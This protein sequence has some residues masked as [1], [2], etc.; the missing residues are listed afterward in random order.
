MCGIA[1]ILGNENQKQTMNLMI[2][3]MAHRG[4]DGKGIYINEGIALGHTRL[5]ILDLSDNGSQPMFSD[6]GDLVMVFNGEVF[7]YKELAIEH[8]SMNSLKSTSDSEV[9]L[10]LYE[11]YGPDTLKLF[12]GM[13]AIL[14]WNK[15]TKELFGARDRLGIKP[16]Y[17]FK[18]ENNTIFASEIKSL[19]ASKIIDKQLNKKA[20]VQ[21]FQ[22]GHIIQPN[23]IVENVFAV[24]ASTYFILK[25]NGELKFNKFWD[26]YPPKIESKDSFEEAC[27]KFREKF[28][29]AVKLRMISDRPIGVFLSSGLD[30]VAILA[31]LKNLSFTNVNTYTI[32]FEDNHNKFYRED[33]KAK[34]ISK[35]FGY[36]NKSIIINP[37]DII[38]DFPEFVYGLDQPSIDGFNSYLV[39]KY[40]CE[41][42]TVALSGLGGD[43]LFLG[44]PRNIY[45]YL[46]QQNK[47]KFFNWINEKFQINIQNGKIKSNRYLQAIFRKYSGFNNFSLNFWLNHLIVN[48]NENSKKFK[49][50]YKTTISEEITNFEVN[51]SMENKKL[52]LFN[53]ITEKEFRTYTQNQLLRDMDTISM[54]NSM[55][56]RV[57]FLD[58]EFI[59]FCLSLPSEYK[60]KKNPKITKYNTGKSTYAES[61]MKYILGKSYESILP[62]DYLNT[63]KQG[64]QLPVYDWAYQYIQ[65]SGYNFFDNKIIIDNF[66]SDFIIEKKKYLELE[67]KLD[68]DLFLLFITALW[69]DKTGFND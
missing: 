20:L 34:E 60:F 43:E 67:K 22:Y 30:S 42:I 26:F 51:V 45:V 54:F 57:P 64:F 1:C 69:A 41:H 3:A 36:E 66:N 19:L 13:F 46:F 29:E 62:T 58:H 55:E 25:E 40:T 49:F 38:N 11:K 8:L 47:N 6:N 16:M 56:I 12:R 14:I 24:P 59:E 18:G 63:P 61:G 68:A 32:G 2:D 33:I 50:E 7:N 10:K 48:K 4:P 53:R 21:L 17:Y 27:V 28:E 9:V 65:K 39:S 52:N 44:Y 37:E 31:A 5:S 23:S 35:H 15:K